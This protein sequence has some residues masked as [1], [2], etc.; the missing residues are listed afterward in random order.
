VT[1]VLLVVSFTLIVIG[2]ELF[3]NAVEWL[4]R[5]L[6]LD[7]GAVG[8]LLAA[9]GTALPE[10][11]IP[12]IAVLAGGDGQDV[13]I[14]S[15]IGA[16]FMLATVA[17]VLIGGS[18][19]VF[20][21]RR[22]SRTEI[23]ADRSHV[24]RDIGFFLPVFA[25]ALLL[26]HI[27]SD[28][29]HIAGA[30]GMVVL[31][32]LYVRATLHAGGAAGEEELP[33]L[34]FDRTKDDP[35]SSV[36]LFGQ[37][38]FSLGCIIGGAELF[39]HAITDIA[40]DAGISALA[41]S[42]IIAPLATELPE[43]LNSVIWMRA[44][45]DELAVGNVTG[46]MAFQSTIPVAIGLLVTDWDLNRFATVASVLALAGGLLALVC[47]QRRHIGVAP[48]IAWTA[49]LIGLVVYVAA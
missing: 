20:A 8:S 24:R 46:A 9:V 1:V 28:A 11:T 7:D 34:R 33:P 19:L 48:V 2:A 10:S 41:L 37:L 43:K 17:M 40:K 44:D 3:T 4:G 26:G 36:E 42:L 22:G 29:V 25:L 39:V 16:P 38:V 45:K 18:A 27:D 32:G 23:T 49:M 31:Y 47:L 13:A 35:P 5:R 6:D 15:I 30:V 14:G 12:V 21:D